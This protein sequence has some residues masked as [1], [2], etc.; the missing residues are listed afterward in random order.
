V[1]ETVASLGNTLKSARESRGYTLEQVSNETYIAER[2]LQALEIEEFSIFPGESYLQGF[3]KTYSEYLGLNVQEVFSLYQSMRG[4]QEAVPT[5]LLV[6]KPPQF[7]FRIIPLILLGLAILAAVAGLVYW[8]TNRPK[9]VAPFV[10]IH[11]PVQWT[12]ENDSFE[13]R[14]YPG[15]SLT[16]PYGD[17]S[18]EFRLTG[19]EDTVT[20]AVLDS[21][22]N[23]A[24]NQ[25]VP[26]D[27]DANGIN[28]VQI[29]VSDFVKN[30]PVTG[31]FLQFKIVHIEAPVE[32][33]TPV[34][35]SSLP[36]PS[37]GTNTLTQTIIFS[38]RNPYPF[39]IQVI[40]QNYCFLRWEIIAERARP[41]RNEEFFQKGRELNIQQI[42]NGARLGM[43]NAMAARVTVIGGGQEQ[44]LD[45]GTAGEVVVA[46]IRWVRDDDNHYRLVLLRLE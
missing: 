1:E 6:D 9:R 25:E 29:I 45:M 39:A 5:E 7:P 46:E 42:Q 22:L 33:S 40:F 18:Y 27:L 36:S 8:I 19:I 31:A 21:V 28:D 17:H 13:R 4:E 2:Y 14:L 16:V 38:S 15:D 23:L 30:E 34:M 37:T 26:V 12:L 24:L 35:P 41:D 20:V 10:E 44:T 3:L 32:N 11:Q 43:S